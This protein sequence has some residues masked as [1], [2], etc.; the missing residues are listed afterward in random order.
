MNQTLRALAV[1]IMVTL[2]VVA[3]YDIYLL[4]ETPESFTGVVP[5]GFTVNGKTYP[6]AY[7][8]TTSAQWASGLMNTKIAN[9]TIML[10]AFPTSSAW[11]F[12]MYDT[13]TSLDIIWLSANGNTSKVVYLV[14]GAAPCFNMGACA[15]YTPSSPANFA[16]EAKAGFAVANGITMGTV[17]ELT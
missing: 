17:V 2:V 7:V 13:N 9:T 15:R 1:A 8:A 5:T 4:G 12:W 11:T 3:A 6:F 14:T 16:I 10:F